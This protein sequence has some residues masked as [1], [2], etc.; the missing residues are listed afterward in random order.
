MIWPVVRRLTLIAAAV[1]ILASVPY[2]MALLRDGYAA[3][4]VPNVTTLSAAGVRALPPLDAHGFTGVKEI[5]RSELLTVISSGGPLTA[6]QMAQLNR[7]CLGL[8][9]L[10]QGLNL[11]R[12]PE[13]ARGTRAYLRRED[14]LRRRCPDGEQNFVFVKQAWWAT[15][16]P[17]TPDPATGEVPLA[18]VTRARPGRYTFNYAVYFPTTDTYAWMNHREKGFPVNL[19]NPQKAYLSASPPPLIDTRDAQIYCSTCR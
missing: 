16:K 8:A 17:P 12:W 4:H 2:G 19:I 11:K 7:G 1:A 14:A 18:S 13:S 6:D 5:T 9:C 10:Y 15:S 3:S